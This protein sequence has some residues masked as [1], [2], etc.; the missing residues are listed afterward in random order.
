MLSILESAAVWGIDAY[1]IQIE[2]NIADGEWTVVHV[3]LPDTAVR[4]S[5]DRVKSAIENSGFRY[6]YKRI[7]VNLAPA[8]LRKE[9]PS[10]DLPIAIG[11]LAATEQFSKSE[12]ESSW[13]IGELAL[14]GCVRSVKG[15]ISIAN[16][17]KNLG[18]RRIFVPESNVAEAG[19]VQGIEVYGI[20]HLRQIV[21]FFAGRIILSPTKWI[22]FQGE[23]S[24]AL[25]D[26]SD[27]K[28]QE[29]AKR[30]IE[31]GVSGGHHLLMLGPPGSGKSMLAKR[32]PTIFP[33]LTL[34]E[35]MEIS[36]VHSVAGLLESGSALVKE[37]PFRSPHHTISDIG[38]I[39]G[40]KVPSP[41]EVSLSHGGVLFLDE[42]PEFRRSTLEVLR[43]P[44]EDGK[45]TISRATGSLTFPA[46]FMLVAAMNPSPTSRGSGGS[47]GVLSQKYR[48]RISGPLLDRIDIQIEVPAL[49]KEDYFDRPLAERSEK[50]RERV[51]ASRERQQK[52]FRG[53]EQIRSNAQMGA[54]EVRQ[55]CVLGEMTRRMMENSLE[56]LK[57]S[58]RG[59]DRVLKVARTI[60]DLADRP[61]IQEEDLFEAIQ[62]RSLERNYWR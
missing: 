31:V 20:S 32:I 10:F 36:R 27:V 26:F 62:F 51:M 56:N 11:L 45:V 29:T 28:G 52:R 37:R 25:I 19:M 17:A 43:Q 53:M 13:I 50:I 4:E 33:L 24:V 42:F 7:T 9:G 55:Y 58:A 22:P 3:G 18:I 35:S 30:A 49:K 60:A 54:A 21:D 16:A 47:S 40:S 41:G 34:E 44:L 8:D 12:L 46:Q 61:V 6:E 39:G 59:F 14:N 15:V 23:S 38:L 57:L 5:R 48:D 1:P 2:V